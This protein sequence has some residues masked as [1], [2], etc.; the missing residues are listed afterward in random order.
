MQ[1]KQTKRRIGFRRKRSTKR[2]RGGV[3]IKTVTGVY[4]GDVD[5]TGKKH[6]KGIM[7]HAD[8]SIYDGEWQNDKEN[9]TGKFSYPDGDSDDDIDSYPAGDITYEGEFQNGEFNGHG[10]YKSKPHSIIYRGEFKNGRRNGMG[11]MHSLGGML[12]G[13]YK[14]DRLIRGTGKRRFIGENEP[15][16]EG[17]FENDRIKYGKCTW[18]HGTTYEGE[19][20]NGVSDGTGVK[21]WENIGRYEG[22]FTNGNPE[23]AG[24]FMWANGDT[25]N[26][27]YKNGKMNGFGVLTSPDGSVFEGQFKHDKKYKGTFALPD[28]GVYNGYFKN[29]LLIKGT[30]TTSNGDVYKGHFENGTLDKGTITSPHGSI[31]KVINGRTN[32]I[33]DQAA[34]RSGEDTDTDTEPM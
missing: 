28:G 3:R 30:F 25:Y 32:P 16:C 18:P 27:E 15:T 10:V 7:K 17:E 12:Y 19:F 14:N 31:R 33:Q 5:E 8:G 1:T 34:F 24:V 13:E 2:L 23:G 4:E 29:G 20:V 9:G 11:F 21:T 22:H 6:G 26:G